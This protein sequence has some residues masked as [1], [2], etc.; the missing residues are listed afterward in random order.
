[1]IRDVN[2]DFVAGIVGLILSALFWFSIDPEIMRF[3]IM[4]PK[5]MIII[6]A[7]ISV[8]LV[9]R[10]FTKTAEHS[11]IFSVGS[12]LRVFITG[13][14][15]FAW[16]IAIIY[17]GFFVSS[18]LAISVMALYLAYARRRVSIPMFGLW[19]LIAL[20]EVTFFYLIFTRLLHVPLPEGWFF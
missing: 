5:A 4:F 3:S 10:G 14:L 15:F 11:D 6:M 2:T 8:G 7:I 16:A 9:I 1:M 12:N 17:L 20:G 13:V 18:V 19:V